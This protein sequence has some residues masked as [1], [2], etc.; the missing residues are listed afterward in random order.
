M[1]HTFISWLIVTLLM[2]TD[3][4]IEWVKVQSSLLYPKVLHANAMVSMWKRFIQILWCTQMALLFKRI[5][6]AYYVFR[7]YYTNFNSLSCRLLQH[8]HSWR[9]LVTVNFCQLLLQKYL[10]LK[11]N[12]I[13]NLEIWQWVKMIND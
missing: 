11:I 13:K 8:W 4:Q 9:I 5:Y 10:Y 2:F 3:V 1:P 7:L 12:V 6:S